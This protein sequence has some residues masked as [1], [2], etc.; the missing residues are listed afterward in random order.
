MLHADLYFSAPWSVRCPPRLFEQTLCRHT[1]KR[2]SRHRRRVR[3]SAS[4]A[5]AAHAPDFTNTLG[6]SEWRPCEF[7]D[8]HAEKRPGSSSVPVGLTGT[9]RSSASALP[10]L[11]GCSAPRLSACSPSAPGSPDQTVYSSSLSG[12]RREQSVCTHKHT[13]IQQ[14]TH[15]FISQN[16][17]RWTADCYWLCDVSLMGALPQWPAPLSAAFYRPGPAPPT[18]THTGS[19]HA[20][21]TLPLWYTDTSPPWCS[22]CWTSFWPLNARDSLPHGVGVEEIFFQLVCVV[23]LFLQNVIYWC[24]ISASCIHGEKTCTFVDSDVRLLSHYCWSGWDLR[25]HVVSSAL[26]SVSHLFL[27]C[28]PLAGDRGDQRGA[29]QAVWISYVKGLRPGK[30]AANVVLETADVTGVWNWWWISKY[31]NCLLLFLKITA[32]LMQLSFSPQE[33]TF[34]PYLKTRP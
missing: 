1:T 25:V 8:H 3:I 23:L 28:A 24:G 34:T 30:C 5:T 33:R 19:A 22:R 31:T 21:D 10:L 13:Q 29:T 11:P 17:P 12:K 26:Q 9:L 15:G 7:C 32:W 14:L 6:L 27:Y 16:H 18:P 2:R 4:A 20:S